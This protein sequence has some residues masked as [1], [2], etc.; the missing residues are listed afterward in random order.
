[1]ISLYWLFFGC[2][3]VSL[4]VGLSAANPHARLRASAFYS[5]F[6]AAI[7]HAVPVRK[8]D[9]HMTQILSNP[10]PALIPLQYSDED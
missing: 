10:Y 3:C 8:N 7:P 6:S 4:R 9:K 5:G 2:L 1:M